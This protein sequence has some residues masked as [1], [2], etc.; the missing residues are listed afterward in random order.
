MRKYPLY[1]KIEIVL[2]NGATF[3]L[4]DVDFEQCIIFGNPGSTPPIYY[5]IYLLP[6]GHKKRKYNL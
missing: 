2:K 6:F 5:R 3:G 1:I 4:L